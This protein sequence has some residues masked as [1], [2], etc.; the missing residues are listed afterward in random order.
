MTVYR[1]SIEC[2][3]TPAV[4]RIQI[5]FGTLWPCDLWHNI[6]CVART[7]DDSLCGKLG[8][9]GNSFSRFGSIVHTDT[10]THRITQRQTRLSSARAN[11]RVK[12]RCLTVR[13]SCN[14]TVAFVLRV[15][16]ISTSFVVVITCS[17]C[18]SISC[19][20]QATRS[21]AS[22]RSRLVCSSW[23]STDLTW[24]FSSFVCYTIYRQF[25]N[26]KVYDNNR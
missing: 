22:S 24:N 15:I 1:H 3:L 8:K 9:P 7:H 6:K 19:R 10:H 17:S 2:I 16:R 26:H 5:C 4:D 21:R 11:S 14:V 12:C 23:L 25:Q 13:T 20:C 18:R